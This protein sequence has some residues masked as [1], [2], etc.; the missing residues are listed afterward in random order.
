MLS[1]ISENDDLTN[2]YNRKGFMERALKLNAN[3]DYVGQ[4]ALLIFA[5]L[6]HLKEV[7]DFYGHSE[8]DFALINAATILRDTCPSNFI[9]GR[10]GG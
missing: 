2:L 8:G 7:N 4:K 9:L 1:F 5:D 10:L 6:D 3:N